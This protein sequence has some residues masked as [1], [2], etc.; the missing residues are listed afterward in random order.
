MAGD[1]P[2]RRAAN[3]DRSVLA[4]GQR[5]YD[6]RSLP[7]IASRPSVRICGKEREGLRVGGLGAGRGRIKCH[8]SG[9]SKTRRPR[10]PIADMAMGAESCDKKPV[11]VGRDMYFEPQRQINQRAT[12]PKRILL[13]QRRCKVQVWLTC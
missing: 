8:Y 5:V 7:S 4:K 2:T 1:P 12:H 11:V 13:H 3:R 10:R 6:R 9:R